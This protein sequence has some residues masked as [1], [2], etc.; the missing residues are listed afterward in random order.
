M[1]LCAMRSFCTDSRVWAYVLRGACVLTLRMGLHATW[2]FCTDVAYGP[3][4]SVCT[5]LCMVLRPGWMTAPHPRTAEV[6]FW[7]EVLAS[8]PRGFTN[9]LNAGPFLPTREFS[10]AN[11]V[12]KLFCTCSLPDLEV[13]NEAVLGSGC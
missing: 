7:K 4:R 13:C 10:N 9:L 8:F 2:S 1:V 11:Q 12:F 6:H 3:T 5:D